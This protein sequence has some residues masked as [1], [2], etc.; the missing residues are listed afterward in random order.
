MRY[1]S[2]VVQEAL[3]QDAQDAP[4]E[5]WRRPPIVAKVEHDPTQV[6]FDGHALRAGV[7]MTLSPE[8]MERLRQ[9]Y[10]CLG[11]GDVP[12]LEPQETPFPEECSL[13]S[14]PMKQRQ[15][16]DFAAQ[17]KGE[18]WLGP[19][20]T[21]EEEWEKSHEGSLRRWHRNEKSIAVPKIW[22][23]NGS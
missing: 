21:L 10:L 2:E 7:R 11:W 3:E 22:T 5:R 19:R 4:A 12:C 20:T 6:T 23:P 14:Y 9:G 13:C 15:V 17:F 16:H 1:E 8:T 18:E